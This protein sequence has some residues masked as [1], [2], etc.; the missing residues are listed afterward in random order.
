[1]ILNATTAIKLVDSLNFNATLSFFYHL[2]HTKSLD[3]VLYVI[4]NWKKLKL[5]GHGHNSEI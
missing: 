3:V 1:M 4:E 2:V 5:Q